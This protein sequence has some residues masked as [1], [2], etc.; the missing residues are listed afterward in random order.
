MYKKTKQKIHEYLH[1]GVFPGVSFALIQQGKIETETLGL[2]QIFPEKE[3]LSS[4]VLFDVASLTKVICTTTVVLQ[5]LESKQLSIDDAV[6][7]H[8]TGFEDD[9]ITIRHLLTHTADISTYIKNRDQLEKEELKAAY[10]KVRSGENLGKKAVYTDAGTII[11]GFML[12][13]MLQQTAVQ[14]FQE[15]VLIPLNMRHS[16]FLPDD[17]KIIVPTENHPQRGLI[18]GET[19]DPKAFRLAE[20]A[21][22]A[23]LFSN[24]EDILSFVQMYLNKGRIGKDRKSV[25]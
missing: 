2:A 1:L 9:K 22:N 5:L 15:R 12:E 18:R 6:S 21:G 8:L 11:L 17:P 24:L 7:Q 16:V 19:H 23:G 4:N 20:H 3:V 25:V 10:Y 14:L 13:E